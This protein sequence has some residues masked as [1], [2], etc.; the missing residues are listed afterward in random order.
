MTRAAPPP[1]GPAPAQPL[2]LAAPGAAGASRAA[3]RPDPRL[4]IGRPHIRACPVTH[5]GPE[6][7]STSMSY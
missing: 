3:A 6:A 4:H 7:H 2:C 5:I 1:G